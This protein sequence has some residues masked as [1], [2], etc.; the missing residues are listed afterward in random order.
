MNE[1]TK[2]FTQMIWKTSKT[3]GFGISGKYVVGWF[4]GDKAGNDRYSYE[5]NVCPV[6]G[7]DTCSER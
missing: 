4:C 5:G 2:Y 3:V 6:G 1:D 7:C